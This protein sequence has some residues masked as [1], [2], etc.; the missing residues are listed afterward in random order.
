MQLH[1][2]SIVCAVPDVLNTCIVA[3]VNGGKFWTLI[4]I[5]SDSLVLLYWFKYGF[6]LEMKK[7]FFLH[8]MRFNP[9]EIRLK[10]GILKILGKLEF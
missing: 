10:T 6:S 5:I 8:E 3:P 7:I 9:H 1:H 2:T 4:K